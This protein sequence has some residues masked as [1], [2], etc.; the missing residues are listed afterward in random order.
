MQINYIKLNFLKMN[1]ARIKKMESWLKPIVTNF[2]IQNSKEFQED[3]WLITVNDIKIAKDLSYLDIFVSSLKN[4]DKLCKTLA[5]QAQE[6]KEEINKNIT[7]RKTPIVRFRYD[8]TIEKSTDLIN[9][10]DN[11]TK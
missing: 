5:L 6:I 9:K 10:I 11:L 4:T 1:E 8:S 7:L 2:L 3:F